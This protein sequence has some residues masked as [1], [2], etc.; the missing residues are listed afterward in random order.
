MKRNL[1]FLTLAGA[2][3]LSAA[4]DVDKRLGVAADTFKE[5][6]AIS[7]KSIPQDLLAK[8]DCIVVVPGLK[9]AA[10]V[11]GGAYGVLETRT[12]EDDDTVIDNVVVSVMAAGQALKTRYGNA[13][14]LG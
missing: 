9:K 2:T 10:F 11:V 3:L 14:T 8:A 1:I 6:M 5:V 7:D 4:S 13:V 12:G